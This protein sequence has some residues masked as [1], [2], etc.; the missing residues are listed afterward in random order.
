MLVKFKRGFISNIS[1]LLGMVAGCVVAIAMGKMNF[2][3]V[4]KAHWFDVVT[5][6]AFGPPTFDIV[7]IE[8]VGMFLALSDITGKNRCADRRPF[9]PA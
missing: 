4:G 3:K 1:V 9:R 5:P 7:M 6:F 8:S 2:D